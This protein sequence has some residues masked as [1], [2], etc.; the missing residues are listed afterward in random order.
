MAELGVGAAILAFSHIGSG[1]GWMRYEDGDECLESDDGDWWWFKGWFGSKVY[2]AFT[3]K[4]LLLSVVNELGKK[5]KENLSKVEKGVLSSVD[6]EEWIVIN[7][8]HPEQTIVIGK[9]LLT[10]FKR[11]L[12]D[13]LRSNADVFAWTYAKITGIPRTI[14]VEGKPFNTKHRLYEFKHIESVKQKKKSLAPEWNEAILKKEDGRLRVINMKLNLRKCSFGIEEGPFLGHLITKQGIKTNPLKVKAIS[15]LRPLKTVKEMQSHNEKLAALSRFLSKGADKALPFFKILKNCTNKKTVQWI[16]DAKEV[17]QEMKEFI[18]VLPMLTTPIKGEALVL[19]G[20]ELNYPELEKLILARVYAAKRLRRGRNSVK[21]QILANFLAETPSKESEETEAKKPATTEEELESDNM[22]KLYT[23]G[24]S[25]S[26]GS[27]VMDMKVK[28]LSI[29]IDSQLV[30][31]QNMKADA[32]IKLVSMTFSRLAKEVLVEDR[33]KLGASSKK[34]TKAHAV[35]MRYHDQWN[36]P[37]LLPKGRYTSIPYLGQPPSSQWTGRSYKLGHRQRHGAKVGKEPSKLVQV[38]QSSK[39]KMRPTWEGPYVVRKSYGDGA[40]KLETL[41]GSPVDRTWNGSNLRLRSKPSGLRQS[42]SQPF[43]IS[44]G[45]LDKTL[46][47]PQELYT[48]HGKEPLWQ[49]RQQEDPSHHYGRA[50]WP[51]EEQPSPLPQPYH[52]SIRQP[53][54]TI[55]FRTS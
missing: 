26:D 21:G 7:V 20:A 30:A 35:C 15:D 49:A 4:T 36:I 5:L 11:K 9:K 52:V 54:E 2:E 16:A 22:W 28:N 6:A 31:N 42:E 38:R 3:P 17:F 37:I 27:G 40:Y 29:F 41:S 19:Q 13:L 23:D 1:N 45:L 43:V 50:P 51:Y 48:C 24:A 47:L 14:M 18:K 34:Y 53:L 39:E 8:K 44:E 10:S 55:E 25:S 12:Q 32:L 33:Y 46:P